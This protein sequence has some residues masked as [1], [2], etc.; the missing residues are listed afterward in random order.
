MVLHRYRHWKLIQKLQLCHLIEIL[1][2][3]Y[4]ICYK[5]NKKSTIT[6]WIFCLIYSLTTYWI[7]SCNNWIKTCNI[8]HMSTSILFFQVG[9]YKHGPYIFMIILSELPLILFI[10]YVWK[11]FP[12]VKTMGGFKIFFFFSNGSGPQFKIFFFLKKKFLNHFVELLFDITLCSR[13]GSKWR[14]FDLLYKMI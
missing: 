7:T 13:F 11:S 5:I 9:H 12:R 6:F 1:H 14:L 8:F 3:S 10:V 2:D 4:P